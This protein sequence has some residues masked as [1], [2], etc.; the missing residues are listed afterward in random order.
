MPA[1]WKERRISLS[2]KQRKDN[3][4]IFG[5]AYFAVH[6]EKAEAPGLILKIDVE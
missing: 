3:G 4:I 5:I 2:E 6:I 1:L